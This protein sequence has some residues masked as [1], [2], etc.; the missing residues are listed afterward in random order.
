MA[1][2]VKIKF[3]VNEVTNRVDGGT[4]H[5]LPVVNDTIVAG[6]LEV[7]FANTVEFS[8]L[9]PGDDVTVDIVSAT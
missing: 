1:T 6:G 8:H 4:L 3:K 7:I 2:K 5:L 9:K